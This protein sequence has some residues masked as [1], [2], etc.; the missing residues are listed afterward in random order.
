MECMVRHGLNCGGWS[1]SWRVLIASHPSSPSSPLIPTPPRAGSPACRTSISANPAGS[2]EFQCRSVRS[3]PDRTCRIASV[4]PHSADQR[5]PTTTGRPPGAGS[6]PPSEV[7]I[8]DI[9]V[10]LHTHGT[11]IYP[12]MLR[13][14]LDGRRCLSDMY[15]NDTVCACKFQHANMGSSAFSWS[16]SC[17]LRH[18]SHAGINF[19]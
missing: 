5:R 16:S 3:S 7:D 18:Y 2:T 19:R 4:L 11:H 17:V 9:Q 15:V 12:L 14:E 1:R 8:I 6:H 10:R 13:Q